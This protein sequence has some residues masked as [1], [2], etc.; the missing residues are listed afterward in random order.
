MTKPGAKPVAAI[1]GLGFSTLSRKPIGTTRELAAAA[2]EAAI[3]DAGLKKT[4]I[5]GLLI[6]RSPLSMPEELPLRVQNDL[7][8]HDLSLLAHV[9]S[10]GSSAVQIIQYAAM[11][12]SQGLA[13]HVVC[14]FADTPVKPQGG[15]N[16]FAVGLPITGIDGWEEQ[17][18]FVSA[19]AAYALA[20]QRHMTSYGTR[21]E[22]LGAYA[23]SCREWA[24]R[25]PQAFLKKPLSM[26]DYLASPFVVWPFRVL[27]CAYPVNGA[28]AVVVTRAD[29]D[30]NGPHSP[31]YI[32]GMGQG[33][34]GRSG[35]R[36]DDAL[37]ATGAALAGER[38][39][40][41][42][43]VTV[44]DITACEFYDAFSFSG[45]LSL[46]E[47]GF[48]RHGEAAAFI[49]AG[50]TRPGGKLP[51][52]TGGG[53]LSGFYLQGMTPVAEGIIQAR[54]TGE[55]RQVERND[56]ILV[57]GS[58]GCFDY[59]ACLLLSPHAALI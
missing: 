7:G 29:H 34:K 51:V 52:N 45:I 42:A 28:I 44:N 41:S 46:E 32:H 12:V 23:I 49:T 50:H 8:L 55:D 19:V 22:D 24:Q 39:C 43:G 48:C 17:Q 13:N 58:G 31:V 56:I 1:S 21:E 27:D 25:N 20:A 18:G 30:N 26:A 9:D 5:D 47:Y 57:T 35:L 37:I 6:N 4:E 2:I 15:G 14:V 53:H 33:H 3:T 11:A 40:R 10:E 16:S 38:A 59:H 36:G 54:G